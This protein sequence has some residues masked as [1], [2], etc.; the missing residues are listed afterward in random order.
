VRRK[1]ESERFSVEKDNKSA[2]DVHGL[3][4]QQVAVTG[5]WEVK[6]KEDKGLFQECMGSFHQSGMKISSALGRNAHQ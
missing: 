2:E 6:R 1:E 4:H 5:F 3:S